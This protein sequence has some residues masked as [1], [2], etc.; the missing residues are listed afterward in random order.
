MRYKT[1]IQELVTRSMIRLLWYFV[2]GMA[3]RDT[4]SIVRIGW[5][6]C[7]LVLLCGCQKDTWKPVSV[8]EIS[9]PGA[10]DWEAVY[11]KNAQ[12]GVIVGGHIWSR[13][14]I[15]ST[16]D[17]GL[18]WNTDSVWNAG[19]FDAGAINLNS[20]Y[21]V[22]GQSAIGTWETNPV[23]W[24][25]L[26]PMDGK[27]YLHAAQKDSSPLLL[28]GELGFT[29]GLLRVL[30]PVDGHILF[31]STLQVVLRG[32][33]WLNATVGIVC[34]YGIV[35]RTDDGG[36]H[37]K[38]L[39]VSGDYFCDVQ[40][41]DGIGFMI[42]RFGTI[43]RSDD[44]GRNWNKMRNGYS[45]LSGSRD[46]RALHFRNVEEGMICGYGGGLWRTL[47]GGDTWEIVDH[48]PEKDFQDC[49][50]QDATCWV[51]GKNGTCIR[52]GTE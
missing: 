22:G 20:S 24:K 30:D 8:T 6:G 43:L 25:R 4:Y 34:G 18:H 12:E 35:L 10:H 7:I 29:G 37:W 9:L 38:R 17:G 51:V 26:G 40:F 27:Y 44:Q 42:G 46:F 19:L 45:L 48:L 49:Y 13:G 2:A 15:A 31:D 23:L 39:N 14:M 36:V 5:F 11:F 33:A 47:D 1:K 16:Q 32:A 28:V 21:F 41:I 52:I 3:I 50:W